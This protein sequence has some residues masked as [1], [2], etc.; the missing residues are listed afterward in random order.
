MEA[1]SAVLPLSCPKLSTGETGA[2]WFPE[3]H[4]RTI[5]CTKRIAPA[6]VCFQTGHHWTLAHCTPWLCV[7]VLTFTNRRHR[8]YEKWQI[9]I[10]KKKS[11][12]LFEWKHLK[13]L[14]SVDLNDAGFS[15]VV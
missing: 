12:Y 15:P 6:A 4:R 5:S 7:H 11:A 2:V 1:G 10:K 9:D 14:M 3:I 13:Q 8:F